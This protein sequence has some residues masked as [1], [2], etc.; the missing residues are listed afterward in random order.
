MLEPKPGGDATVGHCRPLGLAP[1]RVTRGGAGFGKLSRNLS[2]FRFPPAIR[3]REREQALG[4]TW[5]LLSC[6]SVSPALPYNKVAGGL[7]ETW[8]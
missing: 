3:K 2:A 4:E 5:C 1:S 8:Q 6:I 7:Q